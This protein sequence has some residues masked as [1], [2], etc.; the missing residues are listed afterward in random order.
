M[1]ARPLA[2]LATIVA[3]ALV[4][5]FAVGRAT[6]RA[7][8]L[9]AAVRAATLADVQ[10]RL[11]LAPAADHAPAWL[12]GQDAPA[13]AVEPTPLPMGGPVE[14][15]SHRCADV[16]P[17]VMPDA[18]RAWCGEIDAAADRWGLDPR[19]LGIIATIECPSADPACGARGSA[20][21]NP[22]GA[23][24]GFQIM[25]LTAIEI[26]AATGLACTDGP[27]GVT[28]DYATNAKCG[29]WYLTQRLR[30]AAPVWHAGDEAAHVA[31]A[32]AGYNGG[33]GR[34]ATAMRYW[35]NG[36][37]PCEAPIP[38]ETRRYCRMVYDSWQLLQASPAVPNAEIVW[39][40]AP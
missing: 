18:V 35:Q 24:G 15:S 29:A 9:A 28:L 32:G 8:D 25:P 4:A 37:H 6:G 12:A 34:A 20:L 5:A 39:R 27:E 11:A 19:L 22:V 2:A 17:A 38:E 7:D 14:P 40:P 31:I 16:P 30:D 3:L 26:A 13:P 23:R 10:A 1:S 33:P 21:Y 36:G